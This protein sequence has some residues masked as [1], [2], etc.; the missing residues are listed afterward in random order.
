[1]R[2][3]H[4]ILWIWMCLLPLALDYKAP[5]AQ[6]GLAAQ[7]L[8]VIPALGSTL[9]LVMIAPRFTHPAP[10]RTFVATAVALSIGGSVV[11]QLAQGNDVGNYLR[12]LLPFMLFALGFVATCGP[13]KPL[14]VAQMEHALWYANVLCLVFTLVFGLAVG[15]PLHDVRY[16]IV[17]PTMLGLQAVLLHQFIVARRFSV[18]TVLV[19]IA[20]LL[21]ELLSV[22]RSLLVGT[23]LLAMFATWIASP[24]LRHLLR[25][26]LRALGALLCIALIAASSAWFAPEVADHWAQRV[27]AAKQTSAGRDPTTITRLA[28]MRDQFDQVT[29]SAGTLLFGEGYGHEYRYSPI[30]L[31]DLQGQISEKDF[32]AIQ[33]W[34]AGHNFWVYQL[35]AGGIVF[36]IGLPVAVLGALLRAGFACR[37][38]RRVAPRDPMLGPFG[39]AVMLLAAMPATSIGGNPL[40][41]RFSGLVY[42]VALGLTVALYAQLHYRLDV[43]RERKRAEPN[44]ARPVQAASLNTFVTSEPR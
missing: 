18:T 14:R 17:S 34:T 24:S 8:V 19:F 26:S 16:R 3:K 29:S 41:A 38:W 44:F 12:V 5:D 40:G 43:V 2:N 9:I 22:T 27:F 28:E 25:A 10:L 11:T 39:R 30:Y 7:W 4:A 21:I 20:T 13:W 1:M 42:G 36:G 33:D 31:P 15:G 6:S 32:Y 37:R 35:F 23:A